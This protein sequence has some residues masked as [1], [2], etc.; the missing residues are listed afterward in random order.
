MVARV[1]KPQS[2]VSLGGLKVLKANAVSRQRRESFLELCEASGV[3]IP[4][5]EH[6]F[7]NG[8]RWAMDFAWVQARLALES[9]GGVFSG[10]GH[11]R[12]AKFLKDCEKY[13]T[14]TLMGWRVLRVG[15]HDLLK[16]T[17]LAMVKRALG[18]A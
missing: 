2:Q 10:G 16:D 14:A 4:Q 9:E 3:P 7:Y 15:S 17:T 6:R 1:K 5:T 13:N 12:G 18:L 8:R 11:T